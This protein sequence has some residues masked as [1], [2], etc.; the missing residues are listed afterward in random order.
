M[1]SPS[2]AIIGIG[3]LLFSD[4]GLGMH[5]IKNLMQ[6]KLPKQV[7]IV[8]GGPSGL[9]LIPWM[10]ERRKVIF[11]SAFP[12]GNAPGTIYRL[13]PSELESMLKE[14]PRSGF[15][16]KPAKTICNTEEPEDEVEHPSDE[17]ILMET[18]NLAGYIGISPEVVIIGVEPASTEP[19]MTLS[20][21]LQKRLTDIIAAVKNEISNT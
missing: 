20:T 4:Q 10:D 1:E 9:N 14:H 3:S 6:Q 19:G 18:I 11:V 17:E 21:T 7:E 15:K 16:P 8:E 5:V 2:I 12:S 13:Q